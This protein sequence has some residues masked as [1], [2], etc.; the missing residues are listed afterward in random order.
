MRIIGGEARSRMIDAPRGMDTRPT[1]DKVR[2]SLFNILQGQIEGRSVL[3]LFAG[4]GALGL[5]ALSRGAADAVF[6]DKS[7]QAAKVIREN[8]ERLGYGSKTQVVCSDWSLAMGTQSYYERNVFDL[9]FMDPPYRMTNTGEMCGRMLERGILAGDAL[10]VIEHALATPPMPGG[11]FRIT[12]TRRYGD[13][14]ITFL[15]LAEREETGG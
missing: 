2:E 12:D 5:E 7:R 13:T 1:Q 3:D 15:R 11:R 6:V 9:V 14:G 8:I 10:I 4:S